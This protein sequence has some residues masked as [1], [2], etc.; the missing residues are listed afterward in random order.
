MKAS[1]GNR[2]FTI[3]EL[4]VV[5]VVIGILAAITVVSYTGITQRAQSASLQ[6]DLNNAKTQLA[7][8]Q[9]T[10]GTYP[11]AN[12]CS[13]SP[14]NNTI[15][16]KASS[17]NY[18]SYSPVNTG[19]S[20]TGFNIAEM[21]TS[22]KSTYSTSDSSIIRSFS[23][24]LTALATPT[25][26]AGSSPYG[27]AISPDGA[28]LYVTNTGS[29][30]ISMYS[31]NITTGALTALATPTIA[32]GSSPSKTAISS[33]G[34]SAYT[35]NSGGNTLSMYSRNA[36][37]GALTAL[38]SPT[39]ATG[40]GPVDIAISPDGTSVYVVNNSDNNI[41]MYSRNASTGALTAFATPTIA[42]GSSP[43]SIVVSS[44]GAS[45]YVANAGGAISVLS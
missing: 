4:L 19:S 31:R 27:V 41:S 38:V 43:N 7:M 10:N 24:V 32:T 21:N 6:S 2:A 40:S 13:A 23:N 42:T 30:T 33:D 17:G 29:S 20:L 36:S 39:I 34:I 44:D 35:S 11:S 5:I 25:I 12:D 14:A 9:T 16:L 26:A 45:V 15:C 28:S 8:Y 3:V 18:V 1:D 22:S 37:T